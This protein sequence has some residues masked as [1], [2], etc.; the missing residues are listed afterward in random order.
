MS[1]AH[2]DIADIRRELWSLYAKLKEDEIDAELGETMIS[3][4][5]AGRLLDGHGR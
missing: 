4:R 1:D 3:T 2:H 5:D